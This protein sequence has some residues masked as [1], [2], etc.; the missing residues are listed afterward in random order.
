MESGLLRGSEYLDIVAWRAQSPSRGQE[1]PQDAGGERKGRAARRGEVGGQD[2]SFCRGP[3]VQPLPSEGWTRT[4]DAGK[5]VKMKRLAFRGFP[6]TPSRTP[7]LGWQWES[8]LCSD[9][10][11]RNRQNPI[12][13][14]S[15]S[16]H[17]PS[18]EIALSAA[19][20]L[21]RSVG[22]YLLAL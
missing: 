14:L 17:K 13:V 19:P 6:A 22:S 2:A 8:E 10:R 3:E 12:S 4:R 18:S 16:F 5:G 20:I 1:R 21:S 7:P 9:S 11:R 15:L